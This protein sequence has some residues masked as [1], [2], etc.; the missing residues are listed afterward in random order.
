MSVPTNDAVEILLMVSGDETQTIYAH[1]AHLRQHLHHSVP[2][3]PD[4]LEAAERNPIQIRKLP[5]AT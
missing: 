4:I 3:H 5:S 1:A 2:L